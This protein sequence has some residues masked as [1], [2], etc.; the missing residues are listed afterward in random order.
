MQ[1]SLQFV[2]AGVIAAVVA[3]VCVTWTRDGGLPSRSAAASPGSTAA[4]VADAHVLAALARLEVRI[5]ELAARMDAFELAPRRALEPR[6]DGEPAPDAASGPDAFVL[7]P[8]EA[9]RR[10]VASFVE[11]EQGDEFYRMLVQSHVDDLTLEISDLV[12]SGAHVDAL[13]AK[14]AAMLCK[15]KFAARSHVLGALLGAL[16]VDPEHELPHA[17]LEAL[18]SIGGPLVL[19]RVEDLVFTL[20]DDDFRAGVLAQLV[21]SHGAARNAAVARLFAQASIDADR[22]VL[23]ALLGDGDVDNALATV[24]DATRFDVPVRLAAAQCLGDFH[25]T[26]VVELIDW[27]LGF[28]REASVRAALG[29]ARERSTVLPSWHVL[30]VI[31][32]PNAESS[33]DDARAWAPRLAQGGLQWL[34]VGF[35]A[36]RRATRVRIHEVCTAGGVVRVT[37]FGTGGESMVVWSGTDP[38]TTPGVFTVDFAEPPFAVERVRIEIDTDGNQGWEEIDAVELVGPDGNAWAASASASSIYGS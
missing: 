8:F 15:P 7:D 6:D 11:L 33:R 12:G 4:S 18:F 19:T 26:S 14:L 22:I 32:P 10:F 31:G 23:I 1:K 17:A 34:E 20:A 30:Q 2:A 16:L 27:W 3:L 24:R 38:L 28:E 5:D 25:G 36:P 29:A 13:K 35:D 21:Y 37:A 9:L